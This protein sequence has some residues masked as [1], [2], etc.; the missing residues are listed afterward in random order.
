MMTYEQALAFIHGAHTFG[1]KN[2]LQNMHAMLSRLDNPQR[3]FASVHIGGTNGKGSTCAFIQAGLRCAG[4]RTGLYT[5]PFLTRYNE[6]MRIDGVPIADEALAGVT[7]R[8]ADVV[9]GLRQQ[10]IAPTEFEI[11]TAIAFCFFAEEGVDI[12]VIEVGLGGRL[13]PT[14]VLQPLVCGIAAIDMDHTQ[15]LGNTLE[16]IATEKAGIIKHD[17]PLVL[18]AQNDPAVQ[19]LV[20]RLCRERG[21]EFWLARPTTGLPLGL[22]GAHQASNAGVADA[23]LRL[24][25]D[26]GF[27]EIDETSISAGLRRARWPGRLEWLAGEPR[28]LLDGAHNVQGARALA[29]Y[30]RERPRKK[31]VLICGMLR[32]KDWEGMVPHLASFA[33][34]VIAVTPD[35]P[36]ALDV[37]TLAEAFAIRDIPTGIFS[38][39][40]A[41]LQLAQTC[42]GED[43]RIVVAGSLYLVGGMRP[44]L[45]GAENTLLAQPRR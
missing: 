4:Y 18:S 8:V 12:A 29:D 35:S 19:A 27:D 39:Y 45:T 24:L 34:E 25:H 40:A 2:G 28:V 15:T 26:R 3:R 30:I 23:V 5:S 21:A 9:Y 43:G 11:G 36:R 37:Q 6:R 13:D 32:D 41:A 33:D 20:S 16:A 10:G 14:N 44:L 31:T 22:L 7:G 38:D 42:A 1:K 17:T